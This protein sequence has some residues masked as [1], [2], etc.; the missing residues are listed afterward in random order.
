MAVQ[1]HLL[2]NTILIRS[3]E[4]D[5]SDSSLQG[6][7]LKE[8]QSCILSLA[9][10]VLVGCD[11]V[12]ETLQQVTTAL[13]NSDITDKETRLRGLEQVTKAT[14]LG[15]LLPV[16]LT[17]LMHPNLQTLTLA[18]ALMPQL[19]QLVLYTSQTALLLK[20]QSP[21]FTDEPQLMSGSLVQG[22]K[23]RSAEDK[24]VF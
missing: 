1:N 21:L 16:L 18:D 10:K 20:T 12:L 13:I 11:E 8:L 23:P 5:D 9:T 22:A 6:E 4:G 14:M 24:Y 15:H 2:S 17:T 19:V 3:D 7:T